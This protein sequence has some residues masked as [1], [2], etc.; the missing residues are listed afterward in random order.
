VLQGTLIDSNLLVS[1]LVFDEK[2]FIFIAVCQFVVD[3]EG[4]PRALVMYLSC[5]GAL[6]IVGLLLL[7]LLLLLMYVSIM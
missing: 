3:F 1:K 7:L 5:Y 2:L 6:E 4:F